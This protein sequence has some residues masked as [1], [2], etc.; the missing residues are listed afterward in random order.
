MAHLSSAGTWSAIASSYGSE[1][2]TPHR[3]LDVGVN[4]ADGSTT[5]ACHDSSGPPS[6]WRV[7]LVVL[8]A[9]ALL[10]PAALALLAAEGVR[11]IAW[12]LAEPGAGTA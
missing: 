7:Q 9:P 1:T 12:S 11:G 3:A 4:D 10:G 6:F 2:N 8:I 5:M